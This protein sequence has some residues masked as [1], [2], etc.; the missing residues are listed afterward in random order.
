MNRESNNLSIP[1]VFNGLRNGC[2]T[3]CWSVEVILVII[4]R[5]TTACW[6]CCVYSRSSKCYNIT[7]PFSSHTIA[8]GI[9][10]QDSSSRGQCSFNSTSSTGDTG[11]ELDKG[12]IRPMSIEREFVQPS[13][14][15][16]LFAYARA[17]ERSGETDRRS[18]LP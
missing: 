11:V 9:R 18:H 13:K 3:F 15:F 6:H 16:Q 8:V 10:S 7:L 4:I 1:N 5:K 17:V 14:Q 12:Q 2:K